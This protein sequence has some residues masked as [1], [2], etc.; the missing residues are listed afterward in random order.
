MLQ[1]LYFCQPFRELV[2][3]S[4]DKSNPP[5]PPTL[6][7]PQPTAP[8]PSRPPGLKGFRRRDMSFDGGR[9]TD[10]PPANS[11][12]NKFNTVLTAGGSGP[13]I[14]VT[15][16]TLFSALRSLFLHIALN[17]SDKGTVSPTSF[18][19]KVKK[20]NE[21]Y[22]STMHQDAHEF[23]GFLLNKIVED[24]EAEMKKDAETG[25]DDGVYIF[26]YSSSSF[27]LCLNQCL[28]RSA[29]LLQLRPLHHRSLIHLTPK[30]IDSLTG[31]LSIPCLKARSQ[32][33]HDVSPAKLFLPATNLSL[34]FP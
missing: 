33:K 23:L 31:P 19:N 32:V 3:D 12:P 9:V 5:I 2:C 6:L 8:P 14:P 28:A 13:P 22:R 27:N 10:D 18:I 15:P 4:R 24:L 34:I 30:S 1:A 29:R 16:P 26:D 17:P 11:V 21:L 7:A 25:A 20:E